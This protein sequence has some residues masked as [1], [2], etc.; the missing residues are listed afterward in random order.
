MKQ[1]MIVNTDS[2]IVK[3]LSLELDN[4]CYNWSWKDRPEDTTPLTAEELTRFRNDAEFVSDDGRLVR[5]RE[6]FPAART[7]VYNVCSGEAERYVHRC[8]NCP[9]RWDDGSCTTFVCFMED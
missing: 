8:L 2:G 6:R 4:S 3:Y 9:Y 5:F 1:F 7:F